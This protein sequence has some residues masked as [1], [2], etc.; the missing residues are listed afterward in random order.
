MKRCIAGFSVKSVRREKMTLPESEIFPELLRTQLNE[1]PYF[2]AFLRSIE[3]RFY[4][5]VELAEPVLDLG[6]GDGH[7][8]ARTF[9]QT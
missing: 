3:A 9:R 7:F 4:L 2:R 8:A 1:V 6:T 5:G